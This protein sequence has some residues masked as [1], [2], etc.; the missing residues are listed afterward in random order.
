[1]AESL[2]IVLFVLGMTNRLTDLVDVVH[3]LIER[4]LEDEKLPQRIRIPR[5]KIMNSKKENQFSVFL[6]F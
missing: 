1:M 4:Q 5:E 3:D 6:F 2:S